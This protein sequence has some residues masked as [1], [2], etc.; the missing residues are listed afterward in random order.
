MK[1]IIQRLTF[2]DLLQDLEDTKVSILIDGLKGRESYSG[3][4]LTTGEDYMQMDLFGYDQG[5][6][7]IKKFG[8]I[9]VRYDQI[10]SILHY[11]DD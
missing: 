3:Y 5:M 2:K 8:F 7:P 9:S 11:T 4:V 6:N 1:K 10:V